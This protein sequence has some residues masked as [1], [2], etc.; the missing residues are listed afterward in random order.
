MARV[1]YKKK[2]EFWYCIQYSGSNVAEM[3]AFCPQCTY[4]EDSQKL[5]FNMVVVEPT[6]WILEDNAK[7]YTMMINEQF[8]VFFDLAP[9]GPT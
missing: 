8:A 9:G 7:V 3:I 2:P 5:V 1:R 6:N 4:D